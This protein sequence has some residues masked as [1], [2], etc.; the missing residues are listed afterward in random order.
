MSRIDAIDPA[1]AQG[2]ARELL[3][4]VQKKLGVTPNLMR[5]MAN[6]PAVLD[7]YLGLGETLGRGGFDARARE[8]VALTVAGANACDYCASA[9]AAISKG[10]K[11]DADEI[12]A[13]LAGRS[14]D[15]AL[16]AALRFARRVVEARGFVTDDD[17]A[18]VRRAGHGDGE[19]VE[20]V[21]LVAMNILT[22]Y[23]NHVAQTAIDFPAVD[24]SAHRVA[25]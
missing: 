23:I 9:H 3:D 17:L 19:I 4:G 12:E 24:A 13:R 16:D 11:V 25:A 14:A 22:N 15:P 20:L 6:Q 7:A 1:T 21:A 5:V 2:R 18:A 10:L 8:A